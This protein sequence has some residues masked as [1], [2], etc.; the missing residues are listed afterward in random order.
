MIR[1]GISRVS[2]QKRSYANLICCMHEKGIWISHCRPIIHTAEHCIRPLQKGA[3]GPEV[4]TIDW[5]F[6]HKRAIL[7]C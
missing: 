6:V 7:R 3:I 2:I 5:H 4:L 1:A